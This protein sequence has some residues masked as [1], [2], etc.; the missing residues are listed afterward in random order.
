MAMQ[1]R[2]QLD[3]SWLTYSRVRVLRELAH[4]R[5]EREAA[6][7]LGI[8]YDGVRSIIEAIKD[9]TGLGSVR[10]LRRWWRQNREVWLDW[11]MEQAGM[12]EEGY[13]R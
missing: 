7:T 11:V 3:W 8:T 12:G 1:D 2:E 5:S 9:Q 13:G 4:D 10:E 6:E